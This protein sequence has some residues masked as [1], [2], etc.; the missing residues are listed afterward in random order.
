MMRW[1]IW[2]GKVGAIDAVDSSPGWRIVPPA[3]LRKAAGKL[4]KSPDLIWGLPSPSNT[5]IVEIV[6]GGT[7]CTG[8]SGGGKAA[9]IADGGGWEKQK[10]TLF[11]QNWKDK[12][13]ACMS[14]TTPAVARNGRP[15]MIDT[16][17]LSVMSTTMK[18]LWND[19]LTHL[20]RNIL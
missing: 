12:V 7:I 13:P 10:S 2:S 9:D 16:W 1:R 19:E 20:D 5:L 3:Q 15:K 17:E 11:P 4:E 8:I 18:S 14:I 6:S